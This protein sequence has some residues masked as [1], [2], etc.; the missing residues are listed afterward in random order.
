MG[1]KHASLFF[2]VLAFF[3]L[4]YGSFGQ[5]S[6]T[7][8]TD[9]NAYTVGET[10][11]IYG[12]TLAENVSISVLGAVPLAAVKLVPVI[13]GKFGYEYNT[14]PGDSGKVLI[15]AEAYGSMF[16]AAKEKQIS[17]EKY[18]HSSA[19]GVEFIT[20]ASNER[21]YRDSNI[22]IKV[23]VTESSSAV[24]NANV[25]CIV[26]IPGSREAEETL[27]LK[28]VGEFFTDTYSFTEDDVIMGG[29]YYQNYQIGRG[30]P[31]QIWVIK[32]A[33]EKNDGAKKSGGASRPI[34]VAN[35]P[36]I[37]D[38]LSPVKNVIESGENL[39]IIVRAYYDNQAP[40]KN[41]VVVIE[42]SEGRVT[43]LNRLTESG[44]FG[45]KNY[46]SR[47]DNDY[48]SLTV[49]AS[50][51]VGNA[52]K[53]T[54]LFRVIRNNTPDLLYRFWWVLPMIMAII[55]LTIYLEKEMENTYFDNLAKPRKLRTG[56]KELQ[57]EKENISNAK[58]ALERNYYKRKV[59]EKTFRQM[60][61]DY[62][63]KSI[64]LDIKIKRM[65][66]ELKEFG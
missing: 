51:E 38:I 44:L 24:D 16:S 21:F 36:I 14:R 50:D 41:A 33:A 65:K 18:D 17:V 49:S 45:F 64:D 60:M 66:D 27:T 25:Y 23:R 63:R 35:S 62:E 56:L 54:V 22:T 37:I 52:G 19:L 26:S 53:T 7:I 3:F 39:D 57:E 43:K 46:D 34:R 9:K 31:T 55:I 28:A 8:G 12:S 30:D 47:S 40:A 32:C 10:V 11:K 58:T 20:P 61:E 42:D 5:D 48:L 15:R 4:P 13:E 59:D 2:A 29:I 1:R 6:L